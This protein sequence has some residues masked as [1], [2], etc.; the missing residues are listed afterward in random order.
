MFKIHKKIN[1]PT[2]LSFF[3]LFLHL[4]LLFPSLSFLSLHSRRAHLHRSA[5]LP[6]STV[7][8]LRAASTSSI[9]GRH[10]LRRLRACLRS[11]SLHPPSSSCSCHSAVILRLG[12]HSGPPSAA[13]IHATFGAKVAGDLE[14]LHGAGQSHISWLHLP[15]GSRKELQGRLLAWNCSKM[16][17]LVGLQPEPVLE[18]CQTDPQNQQINP[19]V[20]TIVNFP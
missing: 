19:I 11:A 10:V 13:S 14:E 17:H 12:S 6:A 16:D 9:A 18:P 5:P 8:Q 20:Q 4:F 15:S 7:P 2:Y 3:F 1:Y